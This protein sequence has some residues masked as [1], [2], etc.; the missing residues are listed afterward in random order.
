MFSFLL[1]TP[2]RVELL[3]ICYALLYNF[4]EWVSSLTPLP[5]THK[6]SRCFA[7]GSLFYLGFISGYVTFDGG[8]SL[9]FP[10]NKDVEHFLVYLLV[11]YAS[12]CEV[13]VLLSVFIGIFG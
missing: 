7:V 11:I 4:P 8:S 2:L 3:N 6:P 10:E 12:D 13:T 9:H 1:Y 5:P